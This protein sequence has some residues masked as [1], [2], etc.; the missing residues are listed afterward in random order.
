MFNKY[1]YPNQK[2]IGRSSL[3][4]QIFQQ[5]DL[6]IVLLHLGLSCDYDFLKKRIFDYVKRGECSPI[7]YAM[8]VDRY[9]LENTGE[10]FYYMY[11]KVNNELKTRKKLN[12]ERKKVGLPSI[13][14]HEFWKEQ[15]ILND[16]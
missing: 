5:T 1:G 8:V 2:K 12:F 4:G 13:E 6:A 16:N 11:W 14:H 10:P 15:V 9:M 3:D 7:T